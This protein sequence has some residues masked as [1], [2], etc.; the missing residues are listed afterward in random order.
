MDQASLF[1][2]LTRIFRDVF[3]QDD[4]VLHADTS[5]VDIDGWDSMKQVEILIATQASFGVKF[6]T[7]EMDRLTCVG[8]LARLIEAKR[9]V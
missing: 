4:I 3:L 7:R 6:T 9:Q 2:E 8:D 5:A 1:D